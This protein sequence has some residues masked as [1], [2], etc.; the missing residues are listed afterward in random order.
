MRPIAVAVLA[1]LILNNAGTLFAQV[2]RVLQGVDLGT[3]AGGYTRPS[4]INNRGEIVGE[5]VNAAQSM[6]VAFLWTPRLGF[7]EIAENAAAFD[8]NDR[9]QV[10]GTWSPCG[11]GEECAHYGFLWTRK[12]GFRDLGS[13]IPG[14]IN[15]KGDMAGHCV[16]GAGPIFQIT[17][18]VMRQGVLTDLGEE[19]VSAAAINARGDVIGY[20]VLWRRNG[21]RVDFGDVTLFDMNN[22]GV[23]VGQSCCV[24]FQPIATA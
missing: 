8:I 11:A 17:A 14:S 9:G 15:N 5:A 18:C 16:H 4:A 10:V 12:E 22:R 6:F 7:V 2:P 13:F 23:I 21:A 24:D 19:G 20:N 3:F 1:V